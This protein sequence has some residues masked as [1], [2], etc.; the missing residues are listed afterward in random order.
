MSCHMLC[1]VVSGHAVS[2]YVCN[3]SNVDMYNSMFVDVIC[4]E[5]SFG[6]GRTLMSLYWEHLEA[7]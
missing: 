1:G 5:D 4:I 2:C 3:L 7:A 6:I